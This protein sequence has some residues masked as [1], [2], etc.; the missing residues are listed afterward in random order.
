MPIDRQ[1][2]RADTELGL[3]LVCVS[4]LVAWAAR[5][6]GPPLYDPM[7]SAALPYAAA[8]FLGGCGLWLLLRAFQ[9]REAAVAPPV[10]AAAPRHALAAQFLLLMLVYAASMQTLGY[11]WSTLAFV[12]LSVMLLA[13]H[14]LRGQWFAALLLA[15]VLGFGAFWLFT[16]FFF[17]DLPG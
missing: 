2:L 5:S 10:P 4:A 7:G 9:Q 8:T 12:W 17:I 13:Q 1:Q 16:R 14:E 11:R 15:I 6:I 3:L